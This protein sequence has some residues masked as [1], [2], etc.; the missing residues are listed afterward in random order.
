MDYFYFEIVL[1]DKKKH[2]ITCLVNEDL[3]KYINN[4]KLVCTSKFF[5]YI[6]YSVHK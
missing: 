3:D 6:K 2:I 1:K 5:P 4:D